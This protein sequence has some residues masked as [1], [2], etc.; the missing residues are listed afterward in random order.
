MTF[1]PGDLVTLRGFSSTKEKPIG[2]VKKILPGGTLEIFWINQFISKRYAL[3]DYIPSDK[4]QVISEA[5][6]E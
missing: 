1:N 6:L 2:M 3:K 5:L 4:L